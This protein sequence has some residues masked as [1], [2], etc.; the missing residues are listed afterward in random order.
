[1]T[2]PAKNEGSER[3]AMPGRV[4]AG[5]STEFAHSQKVRRSRRHRCRRAIPRRDRHHSTQQL[6]D[7]CFDVRRGDRTVVPVL[8]RDQ[9]AVRP[10]PSSSGSTPLALVP[11]KLRLPLPPIGRALEHPEVLPVD[12]PCPYVSSSIVKSGE[13]QL[14]VG[15]NRADARTGS[16]CPLQRAGRR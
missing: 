3:V 11:G 14:A 6:I 12:R 1:M 15:G 16:R 5:N 2:P 13:R 4:A 10:P 7:E 9:H 8:G